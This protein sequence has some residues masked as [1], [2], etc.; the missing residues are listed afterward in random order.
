[1]VAAL[2][3]AESLTAVG[4][5]CVCILLVFADRMEPSQAM[6]LQTTTFDRGQSLNSMSIACSKHMVAVIS[7]VS[8]IGDT[9]SRQIVKF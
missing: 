9:I 7:G 3:C 1:M 5:G 4:L 2:E 6:I 8:F